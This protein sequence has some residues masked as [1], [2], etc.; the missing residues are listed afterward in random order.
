MNITNNEEFKQRR[1]ESIMELKKKRMKAMAIKQMQIAHF[2]NEII[3]EFEI[4]NA[5]FVTRLG[6][7]LI[8]VTVKQA[9]LVKALEEEKGNIKI[10]HLEQ[11]KTENKEF[12]YYFYINDKLQKRILIEQINL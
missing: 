1:K 5:I 3:K 8:K 10:Y 4:N 7:D 9:N 2:K 6:N 12:L 11:R